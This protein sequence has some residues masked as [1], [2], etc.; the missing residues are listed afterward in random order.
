M[1]YDPNI[2]PKKLK[3]GR[4]FRNYSLQGVADD[5]SLGVHVSSLNK[6]ELGKNKPNADIL[7]TLAIIYRLD[8][9]YF[10]IS[11]MTPQEA[12]LD[13][14]EDKSA[15]QTLAT[16]YEELIHKLE[17]QNKND[18]VSESIRNNVQLRKI[19]DKI[20]EID[21]P[22]LLQRIYDKVD[23]FVDGF[24]EW[25]NSP[26]KINAAEKRENYGA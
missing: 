6:W 8:I 11:N 18:A 15:I 20:S 19:F 26:S 24:Q 3:Q 17:P 25:E 21:N 10:F 7:A 4:E 13:H 1:N 9:N 2:L 5:K 23:G 16:S 12:D 14:Y 22:E